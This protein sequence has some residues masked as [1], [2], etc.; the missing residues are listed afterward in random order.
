MRSLK[1]AGV[2]LDGVGLQSHFDLRAGR[3]D[4][5]VHREFLRRL[6][7][8]GVELA[9]TEFDVKE[10]DYPLPVTNRDQA[11][12]DHAARFLDTAL[13]KPAMGDVTC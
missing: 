11:V 4:P 5:I 9:I 10:S 3:F 2:P 6:A 13:L 1:A 8:E 12:A 7:G